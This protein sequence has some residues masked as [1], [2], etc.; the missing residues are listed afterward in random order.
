MKKYE[1]VLSQEGGGLQWGLVTI[2][3][4]FTPGY[5]FTKIFVNYCL[6]YINVGLDF[7]D[8]QTN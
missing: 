3:Y 8:F 4:L 5:Y 7:L 6:T 2:D 1:A